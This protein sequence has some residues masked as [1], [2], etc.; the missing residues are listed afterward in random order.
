MTADLGVGANISIEDAVV[1]CNILHRELKD[2]RN[3]HPTKAELTS[4]F[5]EYQKDRHG[6][7]KAF[8]ELSGKATRM[9]SWDSLFR[10]VFA[11]RI[12]PF[13]YTIQVKKLATAFAKG[14][15]LD[16]VPVQTI[17]ENEEGWLLA[18]EEEKG[19]STS[20]LVYAS[21][22]AIATGWAISRYGLPKVL[23]SR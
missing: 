20:W 8:T 2:N 22:G 18:K 13:L 1:L 10:K 7:A 12:A 17:D 3:H 14:P 16:Y 21:V 19:S 11:T 6:R 4:M 23:T 9:N 5:A 15:K